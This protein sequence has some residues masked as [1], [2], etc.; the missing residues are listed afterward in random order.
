MRG[1]CPSTSQYNNPT[2][3]IINADVCMFL[4]YR[5]NQFQL[6]TDSLRQTTIYPSITPAKPQPDA[7]LIQI[8]KF[9]GVS[10]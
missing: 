1:P 8:N 9:V 6:H 2:L 7:I 3:Y 10:K 5:L 4:C